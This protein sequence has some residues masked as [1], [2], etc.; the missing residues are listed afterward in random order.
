[1]SAGHIL[2]RA[3]SD[4]RGSAHEILL[5]NPEGAYSKLVN[6]QSFRE[7]ADAEAAKLGAD[8]D[9]EADPPAEL[10]AQQIQDLARK[11]KPHFEGL[12]R[13]QSG[14][15]AASVA[16]S[17]RNQRLAEEGAMG[18]KGHSF[19]YLG[20]RMLKLNKDRWLDYTLGMIGAIVCGMVY[21]IFGI[22]FGG[23][24]G[25]FSIIIEEGPTVSAAQVAINRHE[26]RTQ[27]NQ[28]ALYCFAIAIVATAAVAAQSYYWGASAERLSRKIRIATFAAILRQDIA[29]FDKEENSTG[30]LTSSVSDWAQKINGLFGVTAGVIIQSIFTLLGGA[31]VGLCYGWRVSL[32]GIACMPLNILAGVVRLRVVVLKDVK[33]KKAHEK[34]SQMACEAAGAIRTVASLTREDDCCEL[35][36]DMLA[37]PLRE[38]NKTAIW[39]NA[40]YSASQGLTFL[41]IGL[42]FWYGSHQLVDGYLTTKTFFISLIS[43]TFGSIQAGN[44]FK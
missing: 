14:R 43:I 3:S 35:Y 9:S 44:V 5:D 28:Y 22:V 19:W 37:E 8:D 6:A 1:M 41:V 2:E 16:L 4:S 25:V 13:A 29:Y 36:T 34:S 39:S 32:V 27:G 10:T 42:V 17:S 38:S 40:Y 11:E 20:A 15:S 30:H 7:Q 21:P 23:V 33:V 26:L 12:K 31:I 18:N 24:I